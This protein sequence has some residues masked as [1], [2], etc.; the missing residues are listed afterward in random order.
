MPVTAARLIVTI[1]VA[2]TALTLSHV[3]AL[4]HSWYDADCC[5]E[6][7][8]KPVPNEDVEEIEGGWKY[9]PTGVE[10]KDTAQKQK[11]RPSHDGRFH[12]CLGQYSG[13]PLCIYIVIGG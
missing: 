12:V 8:C 5:S 1:W 11:I 3:K 9:L 4:P 6:T 10:F 7:D 13:A 2:F